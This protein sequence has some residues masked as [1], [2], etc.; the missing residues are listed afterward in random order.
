MKIP[1]CL[2]HG[3]IN[4]KQKWINCSSS[5]KQWRNIYLFNWLTSSGSMSLNSSPLPVQAMNEVLAGFSSRATRNCQSCNDPRR[6]YV[7]NDV[8]SRIIDP[9]TGAATNRLD[10]E[11]EKYSRFRSVSPPGFN[12][13]NFRKQFKEIFLNTPTHVQ[14]ILWRTLFIGVRKFAHKKAKLYAPFSWILRKCCT[15]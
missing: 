7:V 10:D 15:G 8:K 6:W 3:Y 4:T 1:G 12:N 5:T 9:S 13:L 14:I 11:L 2:W